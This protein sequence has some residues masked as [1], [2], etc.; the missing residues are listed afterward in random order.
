VTRRGLDIVESA[1][2]FALLNTANADAVISCWRAKF[3]YPTWRPSTAIQLADTDGNPRTVADPTWEP[4]VP[5]PPYPEY[6]SGHACISGASSQTFH[7]LFGYEGF[8]LYLF[9][10]VTGTTRFYDNPDALDYATLNARI[11]LGIHFRD[12]VEDANRHGHAVSDWTTQNYFNA[13]E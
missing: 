12:S 3:D 1:R 5:N 9:S 8:D 7:F 2:T 4:L 10:P 13:T 6:A 11:W